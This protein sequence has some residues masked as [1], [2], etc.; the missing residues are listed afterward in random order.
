MICYFK[1]MT[2]RGD[3]G[4]SIEVSRADP[5]A[6][7]AKFATGHLFQPQ[8]P[9]DVFISMESSNATQG[10]RNLA[11]NRNLSYAAHWHEGL[12]DTII[13]TSI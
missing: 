6:N 12:S 8:L 13:A 4:L 9:T 10:R 7:H 2:V 5:V 1:N 11:F 3:F